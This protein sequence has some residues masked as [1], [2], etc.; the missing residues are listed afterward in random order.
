MILSLVL[1]LKYASLGSFIWM[2][3]VAFLWTSLCG[4]LAQMIAHTVGMRFQALLFV[5]SE[6]VHELASPIAA[7]K[8]NLTAEQDPGAVLSTERLATLRSVCDRIVSLNEDLRVI[9]NWGAPVRHSTL[10]VVSPSKIATSCVDETRGRFEDLGIELRLDIQTEHT[11]LCDGEALKRVIMILLDNAA[12][13]C[14]PGSCVSLDVFKEAN[15]FL[16]SV[17]DTGE[18]V[19]ADT[20]KN[21]FE[22]NFRGDAGSSSKPPGSGLG[23]TIAKQIVESHGGKIEAFQLEPRGMKFLVTLMRVPNQH[24]SS[25][26]VT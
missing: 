22:R 25:Q 4:L 10:M 23:L 20:L 2:V 5:M 21:V 17:A 26:I 13:Y 14:P 19:S 16:I 1:V 6:F 18:G 7:L 11:L 24:P 3:L 8:T 9:A 15:D 12:K